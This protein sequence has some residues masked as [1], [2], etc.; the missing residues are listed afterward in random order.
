MV[1]MQTSEASQANA[2]QLAIAQTTIE[3]LAELLR[4]LLAKQEDQLHNPEGNKQQ[5]DAP[6]SGFSDAEWDRVS[7]QWDRDIMDDWWRRY[8]AAPDRSAAPETSQALT[9]TLSNPRDKGDPDFAI[10]PNAPIQP[11]PLSGSNL[12]P[13]PVSVEQNYIDVDWRE[14]PKIELAELLRRDLDG[15]G[16]TDVDELRMGLNPRSIDTDGDGISD[17]DELGHSN[18]L[19]FND[20]R[21]QVMAAVSVALV[22][23]LGIDGRYEAEN[24]RIQSQDNL[25]EISNLDGEAIAKFELQSDRAVF[26]EDRTTVNQQID[27]TKTAFRTSTVDMASLTQNQG[28]LA[29]IDKLGD[30]APAGARGVVV[31]ESV[32]NETGQESF[33]GGF[34]DFQRNQDGDIAI[35]NNHTGEDILR[36]TEGQISLQAMTPNDLNNFQQAFQRMNS[37]QPMLEQSSPDLE[38]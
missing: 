24:Y 5:P 22:A 1:F 35:V 15:D 28:Y 30:L 18:P 7:Q 27:F 11:S 19:S 8:Q 13:L 20:F 10:L 25:Y 12:P 16:I 2:Q 38:R 26:I 9:V 31:V 17:R 3:A 37:P 4:Q 32:L 6:S 36:T 14:L 23:K 21:Q 33:K 34:Y 29:A